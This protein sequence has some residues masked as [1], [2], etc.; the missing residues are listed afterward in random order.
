MSKIGKFA[1]IT[2]KGQ[3]ANYQTELKAEL[4]KRQS[5]SAVTL[6]FPSN[7]KQYPCLVATTF[8]K[9]GPIYHGELST[10]HV[11]CCFVYPE[12]ATAL[13]KVNELTA[14]L[15]EAPPKVKEQKM[16]SKSSESSFLTIL[17]PILALAYE[18]KSIGAIKEDRLNLA[19]RRI[20]NWLADNP[21]DRKTFD[22]GELFKKLLADDPIND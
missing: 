7:P 14:D 6:E 9:P 10:S 5:T 16:K 11:I 15:L 19:L 12:D 18:L 4:S 2:S 3:W 22:F 1:I 13:L 21:L 8:A 20:T 17:A